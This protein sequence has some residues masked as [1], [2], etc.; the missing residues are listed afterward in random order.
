M[1]ILSANSSKLQ[2]QLFG[3]LYLYEYIYRILHFEVVMYY[4][5]T[6]AVRDRGFRRNSSLQAAWDTS[7]SRTGIML[8]V[9]S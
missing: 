7:I 8:Y 6:S 3:Y 5:K 9:T 4:T 1:I 2:T